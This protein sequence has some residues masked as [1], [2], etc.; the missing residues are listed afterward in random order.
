[1]KEFA[2][3]TVTCLRILKQSI[4]KRGGFEDNKR[5]FG[6]MIVKDDKFPERNGMIVYGPSDSE[7]CQAFILGV[8]EVMIRDWS[9]NE[10]EITWVN[11]RRMIKKLEY[12]DLFD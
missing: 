8:K 7:S 9:S 3:K 12:Y 6:V 11:L 10:V 2:K 1:M 4:D 5:I